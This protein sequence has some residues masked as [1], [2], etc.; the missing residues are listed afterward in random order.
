MIHLLFA[1][2]FTR[3]RARTLDRQILESRLEEHDANLVISIL[4]TGAP[5]AAFCELAPG[6]VVANLSG[7]FILQWE[8]SVYYPRLGFFP[9][10]EQLQSSTQGWQSGRIWAPAFSPRGGLRAP[11]R[12][13]H[14]NKH[15]FL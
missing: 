1:D 5:A 12:K 10:S 3:F 11:D 4:V 8:V 2:P 14:Q 9:D 13:D 15:V 7:G 6:V